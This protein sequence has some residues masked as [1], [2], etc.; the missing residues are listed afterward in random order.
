MGICLEIWLEIFSWIY[1]FDYCLVAITNIFVQVM[2][3]FIGLGVLEDVQIFSSII[4][5]HEKL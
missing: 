1:F 2:R 5:D 3:I 4:R